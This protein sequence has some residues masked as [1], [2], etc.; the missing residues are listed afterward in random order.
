MDSLTTTL[1]PAVGEAIASLAK[2]GM[3]GVIAGAVLLLLFVSG[4]MYY[5]KLRR[6]AKEK[7]DAQAHAAAE[8]ANPVNNHTVDHNA[9]QAEAGIED[10]INGK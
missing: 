2:L 6:D 7:E 3:P 5:N 9:Q 10:L 8:A 4:I 1:L